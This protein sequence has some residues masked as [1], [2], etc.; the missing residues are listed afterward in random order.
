[1]KSVPW[2]LI[3]FLSPKHD[4]EMNVSSDADLFI[5]HNWMKLRWKRAKNKETKKERKRRF[6][7]F[8]EPL[9]IKW[10]QFPISLIQEKLILLKQNGPFEAN[11]YQ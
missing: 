5:G 6:A 1:M 4:N 11:K 2:D 10:N 9:F 8:G 3:F 7:N